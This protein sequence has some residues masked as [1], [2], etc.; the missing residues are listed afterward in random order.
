MSRAPRAEALAELEAGQAHVQREDSALNQYDLKGRR[1]V[2]TGGAQGFGRAITERFLESGASVA[3]WDLD[4]ELT[5]A[6]AGQLSSKGQVRAIAVDVSKHRRGRS[7]DGGD[8]RRR[9]AA[10]TSWSPTPASPD[11]TTRPGNT[12][13]TSGARVV[14]VDLM[15]VFYCCR[16]IVPLMRAQKYGR[17]VT[18][19]SV[20]GKEGNAERLGLQRR[21]GRRD[22]A[23]EVARQ[24]A[25]R[26][27][28][29]GELH[30]AG[31]GE[32]ANL[33]PDVTV[34]PRL[35]AVEDSARPLPARST[36]WRRSPRGSSRRRIRSRRARCSTS[37]ADGRPTES[38][39][40]LGSSEALSVER[41]RSELKPALED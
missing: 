25:R 11:P 14:D 28:H 5:A 2:V 18:I 12:R 15:S 24:G 40:R 39:K 20:A 36:N 37:A 4:A 41:E 16:A 23:D 19:S 33:R 7:R 30:H 32:D 6:T 34:A 29:R 31:R 17:I 27:E 8:R 3:L 9:S 13:P 21:K 1:A 35:D 38:A 26:R 22:R 10:S